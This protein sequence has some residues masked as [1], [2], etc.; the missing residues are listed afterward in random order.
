MEVFPSQHHRSYI[1][2]NMLG[3][4]CCKK[5]CVCVVV[6]EHEQTDARSH[7]DARKDAGSNFLYYEGELATFL[8][9]I[10]NIRGILFLHVK[11]MSGK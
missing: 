2:S 10:K 6:Q 7:C 3:M 5:C 11:G 4:F 9:W 1:V 8:L